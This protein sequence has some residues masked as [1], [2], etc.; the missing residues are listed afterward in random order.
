MKGRM[1]VK[2]DTKMMERTA[3][4]EM[5][6]MTKVGRTKL[7]KMAKKKADINWG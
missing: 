1:L 7:L 3:M 4:V 5:R 6:I 2:G